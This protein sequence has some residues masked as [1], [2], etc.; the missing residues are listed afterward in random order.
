MAGIG[1]N[2]GPSLEPGKRWRTYQWRKAQKAM[3]PNTIPL[4]LVRMRMKRAAELG[5]D[6]KTYARVRQASGQDILGLLFSSNA[7][8]IIGDG[9]RMPDAR[10]RA[11]TAIRDAQKLS[12]VQPPHAAQD[13]LKAN[14][15]L[16]ATE[17]APRFT[18]SWGQMR[19]RVTGF[20]QTRNLTGNQI[21][22]I[23]DAPMESDWMIAARAGGY[24][25]ARDYF[26]PS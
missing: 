10:T 24:L 8:E 21:L 15:V 13:V 17:A 12:L 20:I 25:A 19:D 9:A 1:H 23:G 6:Y 4:L 14:P 2:N 3:M 11:L 16:D 7:L 26:R 5:M 18:D 22:V